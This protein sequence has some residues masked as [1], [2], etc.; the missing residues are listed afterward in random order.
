MLII[1]IFTIIGIFMSIVINIVLYLSNK[2]GMG[3]KEL[4]EFRSKLIQAEENFKSK[5]KYIRPRLVENKKDQFKIYYEDI[6]SLFIKLRKSNIF[7]INK[8]IFEIH[9]LEDTFFKKHGKFIQILENYHKTDLKNK[10]IYK[11]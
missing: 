8:I 4:K 10:K 9:D 3:A 2:K 7:S 1:E 11:I 5:H 6:D